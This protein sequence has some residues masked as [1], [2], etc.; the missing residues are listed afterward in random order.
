MN[1]LFIKTYKENDFFRG[2]IWICQPTETPWSN[3]LQR[4]SYE[5]GG[6]GDTESEAIAKC[7]YKYKDT[8]ST[9]H[10]VSRKGKAC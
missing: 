4:P 10:K 5:G 3:K 1:T 7:Y 8:Y 6:S 2:D 9:F